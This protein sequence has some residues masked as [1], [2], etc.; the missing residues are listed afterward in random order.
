MIHIKGPRTARLAIMALQG[1]ELRLLRALR[2]TINDG[3]KPA[4]HER[5]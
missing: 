5:S 2:H 3:A 1:D 4:R